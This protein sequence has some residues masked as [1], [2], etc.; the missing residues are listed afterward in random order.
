MRQVP[1]V[2]V[3]QDF[4]VDRG[5]GIVARPKTTPIIINNFNRLHYLQRLLA[6]LSARGYEN[7]YVIDNCSTYGPLLQYY[8]DAGLR[9][10]YL[11]ANVGYLALWTTPVGV[12]FL[13]DYYVYT[14]VDIEPT[15]DCPD[16]FIERFFELLSRYSQVGKVGFGLEI[17]DLPAS[18]GLRDQVV[19]H[20]RGLL[21]DIAEPGVYRAPIDTTFALYRPGAAGGSWLPSMRTGSPYLA[22][23]LPWYTD[24]SHPDAEEIYYRKTAQT[25]S[26]WTMLDQIGESGSAPVMLWGERICVAANNV[27]RWNMVSRGEWRPET[28]DA[29]DWLIVSGSTYLELGSGIGE[30]ALY[31]ARLAELVYAVECDGSK[32]A[33]LRQ[34][35]ALNA[36]EIDNI[37][38]LN[39]CIASRPTA[40]SVTFADFARAHALSDCSL[41]K[42]DLE[43]D[44]YGVLP[45]MVPYLREAR[46]SLHLT[47]YPRLRFHIRGSSLLARVVVAVTSLATTLCVLWM[48]RFYRH[49]YDAGLVRVRMRDLPGVCRGTL[50]LIFTDIGEVAGQVG[51]PRGDGSQSVG[52]LNKVQ[53]AR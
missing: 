15:V 31:A 14:D 38:P 8:K 23:H 34:N 28:Y 48:L 18:Y 49:V 25:S 19:E 36:S 9:V 40:Q 27:A 16:D 37:R 10:F 22:R 26:H 7:V 24:S 17:D 35:V 13:G 11:S 33:D 29:L 45:T 50:T 51:D 46:P 6:A 21:T 1:G 32:F 12:S 30:T 42:V 41:I 5:R 47:L 39:V 43:G 20:E 4:V 53:E 3:T 2:R 52:Q 44:E